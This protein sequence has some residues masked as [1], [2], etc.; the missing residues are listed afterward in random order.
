VEDPTLDVAELLIGP[1]AEPRAAE[2][3][4]EESVDLP[5]GESQTLRLA[6]EEHPAH[7]ATGVATIP[8]DGACRRVEQSAPL[9]EADRV[10]RHSSLA[11]ELTDSHRHLRGNGYTPEHGQ[12]QAAGVSRVV[13]AT[14]F[15]PDPWSTRS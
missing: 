13:E 5:Q 9:V 6:D 11:S 7:G 8:R 1:R 12:G 15:H 14:I 4:A 2:V 10:D 3:A